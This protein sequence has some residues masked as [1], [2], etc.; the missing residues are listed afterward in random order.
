MEFVGLSLVFLLGVYLELGL[1]GSGAAGD[2]AQSFSEQHLPKKSA[3]LIVLLS[4][5]SLLLWTFGLNRT[6]IHPNVV[7]F[8]RFACFIA[9]FL[10]EAQLDLILKSRPENLVQ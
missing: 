1:L 7:A 9:L 4:V 6:T 2:V 5:L 8:G 10:S 3:H